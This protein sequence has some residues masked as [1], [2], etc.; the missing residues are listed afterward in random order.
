MTK[1]QIVVQIWNLI[2]GYN[3]YKDQGCAKERFVTISIIV[4]LYI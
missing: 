2:E 1:F 4:L 3:V